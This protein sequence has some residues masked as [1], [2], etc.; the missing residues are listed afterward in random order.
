MRAAVPS[1]V[2]WH[3]V[4]AGPAAAAT[5][6]SLLAAH[7]RRA[8]DSGDQAV[9]ALAGGRTPAD[10][11]RLLSASALDW[12]RVTLLPTDERWVDI[13]APDS[14]ESMLRRCFDAAGSAPGFLSLR[15]QAVELSAAVAAADAAVSALQRALDVTLLG[16][17]A[18]GH[19]ASLFPGAAELPAAMAIDATHSV[20]VM[21]PTPA[22][23]P[24]AVPRLTLGLR[25][26]LWSR[27]LVLLF[28]GEAKRRVVESAMR[29]P[30][31]L[32]LPVGALFGPGLP[33]VQVIYLEEP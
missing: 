22:A 15:G 25:R 18:D 12:A 19:I 31:P 16:V 14:N 30:D 1:A 27:Q 28:G 5:V 3:S 4:P 17:G 13:G 10:A 11:Y 20:F 21:H 26:L 7:L 6:A 8:L 29:S 24:P 23:P 33:P 2:D 32:R 9:L